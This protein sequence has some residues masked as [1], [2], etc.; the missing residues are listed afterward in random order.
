MQP[1]ATHMVYI[2]DNRVSRLQHK[3]R[4]FYKKIGFIE[5]GETVIE[6]FG[7]LGTSPMWYFDKEV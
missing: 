4:Q 7:N 5:R 2:T 6:G 1:H 3:K